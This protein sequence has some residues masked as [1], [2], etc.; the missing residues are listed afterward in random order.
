MMMMLQTVIISSISTTIGAAAFS[1]CI[2]LIHVEL[3]M[4]LQV[5]EQELFSSCESLTTIIIPSL[6]IKI[7]DRAFNGCQCLT[8][9][10]LPYGLVC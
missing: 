4:G 5:L 6:V 7:G 9:F 3:P 8:T 2:G 10:D 1:F